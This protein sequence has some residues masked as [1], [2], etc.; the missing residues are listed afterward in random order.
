MTSLA[1]IHGEPGNHAESSVQAD[2]EVVRR[3]YD[4]HVLGEAPNTF[5]DAV[6]AVTQLRAKSG[7]PEKPVSDQ[8]LEAFVIVDAAGAPVGAVQD[9]DAVVIFNFRADRVVQLSKAL[10]YDDFSAFERCAPLP[11]VPLFK[12]PVRVY[13]WR[14]RSVP[15]GALPA[16][17]QQCLACGGGGC[18]CKRQPTL[19][20]SA[21]SGEVQE[22]VAQ[23]AVQ[24]HH[25]VRR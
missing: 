10:E 15:C 14:P 23:D 20:P 2:W 24:W 17:T 6:D 16:W 12:R 19:S 21:Q 3:G 7:D 9:G 22:A 13:R 1:W 11:L 5:T 4:A 25:A 18:L 8:F